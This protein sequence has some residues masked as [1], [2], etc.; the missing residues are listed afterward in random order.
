M[1][2]LLHGI[3]GKRNQRYNNAVRWHI[4]CLEVKAVQHGFLRGRIG[5]LMCMIGLV[6]VFSALS[7]HTLDNT[8][9][10]LAEAQQERTLI[11]DPGHGGYDGGAVSEG[12]V[13][14]ADV[15][16]AISR[17][18]RLLAQL[19]GLQTAATRTTADIAYPEDADTIAARKVWDQKQ[20]VAMI[21]DTPN[22]VLISIH[23]NQYPTAQPHGAQV[24][25]AA[26][27]GSDALGEWMQTL[28]VTQLDPENR[29]VA[30]PISD[31]IYLMKNIRCTGVLVE[32]GFLS[33]PEECARLQTDA[34]QNKLSMT[35]LSAYLQY[36]QNGSQT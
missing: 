8:H 24:L 16:L 13:Q 29:R 32:C 27:K 20:R 9:T 4:D 22:A 1:G 35:I 21:N 26:T 31:D 5:V 19:C 30:A 23:Q 33:N 28:L 14:E 17:R 15:N 34:F 10:V 6:L 18:L 2:M 7:Y 25:Y 12:G 11:I 3:D 36:D